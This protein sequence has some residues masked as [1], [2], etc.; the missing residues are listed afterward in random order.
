VSF[1]G[2]DHICFLDG[3]IEAGKSGGILKPGLNNGI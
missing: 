1:S 2:D 3:M